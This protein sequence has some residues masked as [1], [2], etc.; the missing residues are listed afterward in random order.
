MPMLEL[1]YR[2]RPSKWNGRLEPFEDPPGHAFGLVGLRDIFEQD[3]E[4][5]AAEPRD[6]IAGPDA[7][8]EALAECHQQL[9][10]NLVAEGVV[11][12]LEAVQ[13]QEHD[14]HADFVPARASQRVLDAVHKEHAVG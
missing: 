6:G 12:V 10:A 11:D 5:V 1:T 14:G 3:G 7:R 9:I 4:L 13:I 8:L 2:S